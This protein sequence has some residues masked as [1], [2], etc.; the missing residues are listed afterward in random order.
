MNRLQFGF[1]SVIAQLDV[2]VSYRAVEAEFLNEAA[3]LRSRKIE[4]P[5]R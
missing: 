4:F 5:G 2:E 3:A 1:Y